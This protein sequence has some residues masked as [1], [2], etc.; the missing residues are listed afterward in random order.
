MIVQPLRCASTK[1]Q[2]LEPM[3]PAPPV[4]RTV[5]GE[6]MV[7]LSQSLSS[8]DHRL[9]LSWSRGAAFNLVRSALSHVVARA[10]EAFEGAGIGPPAVERGVRQIAA[11]EVFVVD[12]S[13]LQLATSRRLEG[14]GDG[15]DIVV[16]HIDAND[17]EIAG[18]IRRLLDDLRDLPALEL[19]HA[20]TLRIGHFLEKDL[21]ARGLREE[22]CNGVLDVLLDDVVA[23][24][25]DDLV[26]IG[27]VFREFERIGD[28]AL[29]FLIGVL[30]VF[31]TQLLAVLQELEKVSRVLPAGHDENL[32]QAGPREAFDRV[33]DHRPV[34]YRQQVLVGDQRERPEARPEAA[35]EDDAFHGMDSPA[36]LAHALWRHTGL[37]RR[38]GTVDVDE[39]GALAESPPLG[40][41]CAGS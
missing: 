6:G 39:S 16:V 7:K 9:F 12:V 26:A 20:E 40:A 3:N 27:E 37:Y 38:Y 23:E 34:V 28:A 18:R 13:D 33:I 11:A 21:G 29:A 31:D 24:D 25:H 35:S 2:K 32:V 30:E 22:V 1:R 14:L 10:N 4:T 17:R 8:C 41:V 5:R 19:H 15:K 36:S